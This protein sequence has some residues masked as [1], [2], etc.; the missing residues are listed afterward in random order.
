MSCCCLS[1]LPVARERV[2]VEPQWSHLGSVIRRSRR[3]ARMTQDALAT[4]AGLSKRTIGGY[5]NGRVPDSA[6]GIPDGYYNVADVLGWTPESV[7]RILDGGEPVP[8]PKNVAG[9]GTDL[10]A[11]VGPIFDVA[12]VARDAGAPADLVARFRLS[13]VELIR[14]LDV[15][16]GGDGRSIGAGVSPGDAERILNAVEGEESDGE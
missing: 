7:P 14:W 3:R 15:S 4:K 10:A 8:A 12:D 5:E 13:A 6:S 9:P 16:S 1:L 2:T 11:L